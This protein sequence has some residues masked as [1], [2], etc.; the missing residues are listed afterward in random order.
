MNEILTDEV[1]TENETKDMY[2]DDDKLLVNTYNNVLDTVERIDV[3]AIQQ[4]DTNIDQE[5]MDLKL[6]LKR[7]L[8]D[9]KTDSKPNKLVFHDDSIENIQLVGNEI[10]ITREDEDVEMIPIETSTYIPKYAL[11]QSNID[12]IKVQLI[13]PGERQTKD[14][15]WLISRQPVHPKYRLALRSRIPN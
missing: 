2:I 7:K 13:Y 8:K 15:L 6:N 12:I 1:P 3:D 5:P 9:E 14:E 4:S 10:N 11:N